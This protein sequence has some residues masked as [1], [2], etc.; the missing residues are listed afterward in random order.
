MKVKKLDLRIGVATYIVIAVILIVTTLTSCDREV[1][2]ECAVVVI[3]E[4]PQY[5]CVDVWCD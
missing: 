2:E 3:D 5:V 1:C 4:V